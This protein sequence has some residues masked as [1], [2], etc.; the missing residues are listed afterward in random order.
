MAI[1]FYYTSCPF[2]KKIVTQQNK[3]E[4]VLEA[5]RVNFIKIDIASNAESKEEMRTIMGDD[6]GLAPQICN[7]NVYCGNYETFAE[8]NEVGELFDFLKLPNPVKEQ[9]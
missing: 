2:N 8:A 5:K 3:I 6:H 1:T 9:S 7:G 4:Q